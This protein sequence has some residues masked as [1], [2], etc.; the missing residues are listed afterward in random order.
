MEKPLPD[1]RRTVLRYAGRPFSLDDETRI[2][3][4]RL[5]DSIS[6]LVTRKRG[7]GAV[8]GRR[9]IDVPVELF[10]ACKKALTEQTPEDWLRMLGTVSAEGDYA[11]SRRD[12]SRG[13]KDQGS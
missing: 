13:K 10:P 8:D 11:E 1:A 9:P 6:W 7:G 3:P 12:V 4:F 5:I 2:Q